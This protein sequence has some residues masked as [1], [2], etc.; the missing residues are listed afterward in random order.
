MVEAFRELFMSFNS[1][2]VDGPAVLSALLTARAGRRA[3]E[4]LVAAFQRQERELLGTLAS[5]GVTI[6]DEPLEA[7]EL[8]LVPFPLVAQR[9]HRVSRELGHVA[10]DSSD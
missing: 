1:D 5:V 10:V 3:A 8:G 4:R 9:F 7:L 2:D 6:P